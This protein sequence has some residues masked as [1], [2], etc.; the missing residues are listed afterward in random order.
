MRIKSLH[1]YSRQRRRAKRE[2]LREG[3][4]RP[5]QQQSSQRVYSLLL[6]P[7]KPR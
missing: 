6:Q 5:G 4:A 7:R 1:G 2:A 3:L